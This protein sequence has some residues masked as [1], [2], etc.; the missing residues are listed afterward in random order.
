MIGETDLALT[1]T[2]IN[3]EHLASVNTVR[4]DMERRWEV[5]KPSLRPHQ[6]ILTRLV[7]T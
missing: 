7:T 2:I 4:M 6:P 3:R 5:A 1:T